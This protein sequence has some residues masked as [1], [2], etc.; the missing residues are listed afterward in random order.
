[1]TVVNQN[2]VKYFRDQLGDVSEL[3]ETLQVLEQCDWI[4][5][6]AS[7]LIASRSG[8]PVEMS[9]SLLDDLVQKSQQYLCESENKKSW[10]DLKDILEILKE[11]LPP[12][13][14]LAVTCLFKLSEIGLRNLCNS[15]E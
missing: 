13:A 3:T 11:L 10:N 15:A 8:E 12:P 1:M 5:E 4:L 7:L 9:D 2:Q 14:P 6:D